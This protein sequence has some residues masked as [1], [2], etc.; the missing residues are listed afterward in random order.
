MDR[1]DSGDEA[2]GESEQESLPELDLGESM[3]NITPEAQKMLDTFTNKLLEKLE[4]N[5]AKKVVV[6]A[7]KGS[8]VHDRK[9]FGKAVKDKK[10]CICCRMEKVVNASANKGASIKL[11]I[12]ELVDDEPCQEI[13]LHEEPSKE[14]KAA[15]A[16]SAASCSS[17][18]PLMTAT[19][20]PGDSTLVPQP[21]QD[22]STPVF[23]TPQKSDQFLF[24]TPKKSSEKT[25]GKSL[26]LLSPH[27]RHIPASPAACLAL[28]PRLGSPARSPAR[29]R[30]RHASSLDTP[31]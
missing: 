1:P 13:P 11:N 26:A 20:D 4:E 28:S 3:S 14:E 15:D 17:D 19:V 9:L 7:S 21:L 18:E 16:T 30:I 10:D 24:K 29:P 23:K 31:V 6:P 25:P 8:H 2:G 27:L 12:P 5:V 22:V